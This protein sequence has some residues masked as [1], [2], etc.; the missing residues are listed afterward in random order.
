MTYTAIVRAYKSHSVLYIFHNSI[1]I[2]SS[3]AQRSPEC[4]FVLLLLLLFFLR[5]FS[6]GWELVFICLHSAIHTK[7]M[8]SYNMNSYWCHYHYFVYTLIYY[9]TYVYAL[10]VLCD[11]ECMCA[12]WGCVGL[13]IAKQMYFL[14]HCGLDVAAEWWNNNL[15]C[16]IVRAYVRFVYKCVLCS[17]WNGWM[18]CLE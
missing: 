2:I 12:V 16:K 18:D 5:I 14:F 15:T 3:T 13:W 10:H 6:F 1:P 9:R 17:A 4:H 7:P 11:W 8:L